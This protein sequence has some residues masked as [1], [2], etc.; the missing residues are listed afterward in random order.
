VSFLMI[1]HPQAS[2]KTNNGK[3]AF[4]NIAIEHFNGLQLNRV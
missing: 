1:S 4:I 2:T 3:T